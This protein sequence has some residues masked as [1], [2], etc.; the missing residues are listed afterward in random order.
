MKLRSF[1]VWTVLWLAL[2][3]LYAPSLLR[4]IQ[5]S[6][7]CLNDDVFQ[8]VTPFLR[9]LDVEGPRDYTER[10]WLACL[11][12]GYKALYRGLG[13][14]TDPRSI[15]RFLP[16][17]LLAA[18]G[19]GLLLAAYH[20]GGQAAMWSLLA[21]FLS[22]DVF[23]SRMAGGLPRSFAFPTFAL[24]CAGILSGRSWLTAA[25]AV[26]GALLYPALA[27][28]SGLALALMLLVVPKE[29]RGDAASWS[30]RRRAALLA[31][32][33]ALCAAC[34]L[35]TLLATRAYGPSIRPDEL[36]DYPEAAQGGRFVEDDRVDFKRPLMEAVRFYPWLGLHNSGEPWAPPVDRWAQRHRAPVMG[37]TWVF[38][39][40]GGG[41]ATLTRTAARRLLALTGAALISYLLARAMTPDLFMA[42]RHAFYTLPILL[43]LWLMVAAVGWADLLRRLHAPRLETAALLAVGVVFLALAGGDVPPRNGLNNCQGP[44]GL[45]AFVATLPQ[46]AFIAGWPSDISDIPYYAAR[47]VFVCYENHVPRHHDYTKVMRER[48]KALIAAYFARDPGPLRT[49]RDTWGVTHLVVNPAHFSGSPPRYFRP[50]NNWI[51]EAAQADGECEA[52]KQRAAAEVYAD[53]EFFVLDLAR[54][55]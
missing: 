17:V 29:E 34:V 19:A 24:A 5:T 33:A 25:A 36:D 4:H 27:V 31:A 40:T 8:Q 37:W 18:C 15:S 7:H 38:I 53:R 35:P 28:P 44:S 10:Y 14:F 12:V 16:Y 11:P 46:N 6:R 42:Q 49:L 52:F 54:I 23:L 32:T 1:A 13:C 48:M 45:V 39:L 47:P 9:S 26:L 20:A 2:A 55:R 21:L 3:G 43:L 50:F 41:W 30:L 51:L 22:A